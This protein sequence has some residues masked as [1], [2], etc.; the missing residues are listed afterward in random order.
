V[1]ELP[2]VET[3]RRH[4]AACLPGRTIRHFVQ[5]TPALRWP[6]PAD[7]K[8][9]S[10]D[11][12]VAEV[13]R[14]AKYLLL[15]LNSPERSSETRKPAILLHLGM[16]GS[17][18]F[19]NAREPLKAHDHLDW[20]F[21]DDSLLR[22][23]DPRRFGAALLAEQ[24][25]DTWR[26]PLLDDLGREPFEPGFNGAY[27]ASAAAGRRVPIKTFIMDQRVVVGVGNI[28]ASEALF[29][30]GIHPSRSAG[31]ISAARYDRLATAIRNV[32]E[33]A[34]AA[35]GTTLRNYRL[36]DGEMGGFQSQTRVYARANLGCVRCGATVKLSRHGGRATYFC[37]ACQR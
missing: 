27:L 33:R 28:Y 18:H 11:R 8:Q 20:V 3:V 1:P 36:P 35:G 16:S 22:F 12:R 17:L 2:E 9:R 15:V 13:N 32:L 19:T 31:K 30:A 23:N 29:E 4:L 10:V 7:M 24:V 21:D 37:G 34:I 14:R 6:I 5:R 25:G 26:H